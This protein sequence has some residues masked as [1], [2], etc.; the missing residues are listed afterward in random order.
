MTTKR[1]ALMELYTE[2][3]ADA[4][5][6]F[7]GKNKEYSGDKDGDSNPFENF[8]HSAKEA[9]ITPEQAWLVFFEKGYG[10]LK[11]YCR[12]G[13]VY[14]NET[15]DSRIHDAI[16]YL[17]LLRGLIE[18]KRNPVW[19]AHDKPYEEFSDLID[20]DEKSVSYSE[21]V[22]SLRVDKILRD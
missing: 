8:D 16:N 13:G 15:I 2:T 17:I 19:P 20:E 4:Q 9:G 7:T 10:S 14:S 5:S 1:D 3:I 11:T 21:V 12:E 22:K 6:L 18:R